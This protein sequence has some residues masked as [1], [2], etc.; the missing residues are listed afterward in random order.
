MELLKHKHSQLKQILLTPLCGQFRSGM[1]DHSPLSVRMLFPVLSTRVCVSRA[2]AGLVGRRRNCR[3]TRAGSSPARR[4]EPFHSL[5]PGV[6]WATGKLRLQLSLQHRCFQNSFCSWH[7]IGRDLSLPVR[8]AGCLGTSVSALVLPP[9]LVEGS[10]AG[11]PQC[12]Y[13]GRISCLVLSLQHSTP[14]LFK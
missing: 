14:G 9:A 10:S 13:G 11:S 3:S 6:P 8:D 4:R 2:R 12:M 5:T 7:L 1:A